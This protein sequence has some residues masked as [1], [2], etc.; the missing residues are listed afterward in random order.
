MDQ[1]VKVGI[2]VIIKNSQGQV[3]IGK[4]K[5]SHAQKYSIPGGSLHPGETFE[6]CAIREAKEETGLDIINPPVIAVTNNLETY[7]EEGIHFISVV[8]LATKFSGQ[9]K[10]M[11][12]EK[13]EKWLWCKPN[14]LPQPHFDA[15]RQAINCYLKGLFYI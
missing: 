13:C 14:D 15:S 10:V 4:R 6:D 1:F 11:E 5:G 3:L 2:G 12:P 8:L 7:Q 9:L